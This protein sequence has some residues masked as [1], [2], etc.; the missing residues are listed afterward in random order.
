MRRYALSRCSLPLVVPFLCRA[1][2][3]LRGRFPSL[4]GWDLVCGQSGENPVRDRAP[5]TT[6][7]WFPRFS[8]AR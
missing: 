7:R 5:T 6:R 8:R 1:D 2:H 4:R 3:S